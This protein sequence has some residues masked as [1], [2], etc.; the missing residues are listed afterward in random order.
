MNKAPSD[1]IYKQNSQPEKKYS[2][3]TLIGIAEYF[4]LL[5]NYYKIIFNYK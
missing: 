3:I 1:F 5:N 2:S 4:L